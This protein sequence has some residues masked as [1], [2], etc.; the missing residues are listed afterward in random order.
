VRVQ[1]ACPRQAGAVTQRAG[2]ETD[3]VRQP[4]TLVAGVEPCDRE[5]PDGAAVDLVPLPPA[6]ASAWPVLGE[7]TDDG[8]DV[9]GIRESEHAADRT[10]D[11]TGNGAQ[12]VH[13]VDDE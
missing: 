2:D 3:G 8:D 12:D 6:R 5:E 13:L 4:A 1:R 9:A 7:R 11:S 10:V